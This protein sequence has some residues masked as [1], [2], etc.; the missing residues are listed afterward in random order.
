MRPKIPPL[1][2]RIVCA[3]ASKPLYLYFL[4]RISVGKERETY[5]RTISESYATSYL[6]VPTA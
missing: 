3:S 1:F 4:D 2:D 6:N 5:R